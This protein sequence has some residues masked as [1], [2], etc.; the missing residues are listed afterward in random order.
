[1]KPFTDR[2]RIFWL[3]GVALLIFGFLT[4]ALLLPATSNPAQNLGP[5][6]HVP[7]MQ[8]VPPADQRVRLQTQP[9]DTQQP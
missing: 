1:M 2:R 8:N 7:R 4:A 9:E 6:V 3:G 5:A